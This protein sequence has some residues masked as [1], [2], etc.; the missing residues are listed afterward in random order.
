M[1]FILKDGGRTF[2]ACFGEAVVGR[3]CFFATDFNESFIESVTAEDLSERSE[4]VNESIRFKAHKIIQLLE[5]NNP[6]S[7]SITGTRF[8]LTY[9]VNIHQFKMFFD[10][11]PCTQSEAGSFSAGLVKVAIEN[12]LL[13]ERMRKSLEAKDMEIEEY[14]CN[15][16]TLIRGETLVCVTKAFFMLFNLIETLATKKFDF[17]HE[18]QLST[19]KLKEGTFVINPSS[20]LHSSNIPE[21]CSLISAENVLEELQAKQKVNSSQ[22]VKV[23]KTRSRN[24]VQRLVDKKFEYVSDDEEEDRPANG[25]NS[26]KKKLDQPSATQKKSKLAK[27]PF[28]L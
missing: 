11:R 19:V 1:A 9:T 7:C 14:K 13:V 27:K 20:V 10:V 15:G 17:E 16:G 12:T 28:E 5:K 23:V 8:E 2:I 3:F 21:L 6:E 26:I 25:E 22:R 24:P 18:L 4:E